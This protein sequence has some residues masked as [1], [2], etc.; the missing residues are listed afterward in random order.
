MLKANGV[1]LGNGH[2][3]IDETNRL[4]EKATI[5]EPPWQATLGPEAKGALVAA[6]RDAKAIDQHKKVEV[7][8]ADGK[9]SFGVIRVWPR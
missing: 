1:T 8:A 6:C 4:R 5:K 7:H 2:V 9:L 3:L